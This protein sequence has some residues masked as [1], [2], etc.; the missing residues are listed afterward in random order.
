MS[1]SDVKAYS[2]KR[3]VEDSSFDAEG[4]IRP[5][6]I[7]TTKERKSPRKLNRRSKSR[8]ESSVEKEAGKEKQ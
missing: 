1:A 5:P 2:R 3:I 6:A 7:G 8:R 4:Y